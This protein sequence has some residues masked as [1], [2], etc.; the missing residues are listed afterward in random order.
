VFASSSR[1]STLRPLSY[2]SPRESGWTPMRIC[3]TPR[4]TSAG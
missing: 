3:C 2:C 1:A 4:R